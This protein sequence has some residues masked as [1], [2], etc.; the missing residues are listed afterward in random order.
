MFRKLLFFFPLQLFFVQLKRNHILLLFWVLFFAIT[1]K[2]VAAKYGI[3]YLFLAPEYLSEISFWSYFIIGI[4]FGVFVMTSNITSYII[5]S[6]RFPFIAALKRPFLKYCINNS[7][8]PLSFIIFYIV[9][10]VSYHL[11]NEYSSPL[12]I[13]SYILGFLLGYTL[14]VIFSLSYFFTTNKNIFKLLGISSSSKEN[15]PVNSFMFK[16]DNWF[17]LLTLKKKWHIESYLSTPFT[18]KRARNISH[19]DEDMLKSVFK[20]NHLN[21]SLFEIGIFVSLII[22]GL[23]R[24]NIYFVIPAGASV[25]LFFAMT[26]IIMSAVYTWLKGWSTIF[27][28]GLFFVV[29]LLSSQQFFSYTNMAYGI[30][31]NTEKAEYS[32]NNL[33]K[34]RENQE[35]Y[36]NDRKNGISILENWKTKNTVDN[37][38]PKLVFI[39][40]SGGGSRSMLWTYHTLQV[41]DSILNGKFISHIH[42]ITGSSGGMIGAAYLRELYL[43]QQKGLINSFHDKRYKL[44]MGKDLLNPIAFSIATNDFLIRT[45]KFKSG[46]NTYLKDRAFSFERQL[47]I[48]TNSILKK[49]LSDYNSPE[50][51][52]EIPIMIFSPSVINDGRRMLISSQPI[53]YLSNNTPHANTNTN[54][55]TENFEFNRMFK[56]QGASNLEFSSAIRMSATFPYILPSVSLPSDPEIHVM[57]AGMRDNY[58]TLST[59]KFLFTFKDW[60]NENTS[61]VIILQIRDKHKDVKIKKEPLRSIAESFSSPIGSLFDNLF[62][63]QDYNLDNMMQYL[64][65]NIEKPI[66]VIDFELE[67]FDNEISLSWHLTTKEKEKVINSINSKHNQISLKRLKQLMN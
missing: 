20:Q 22:L 32:I 16:E 13:T 4:A 67:N 55:I 9:K 15:G 31:Y 6:L 35:H 51:K 2:T 44:N 42:L 66:D 18:T 65:G 46:N 38:K 3:P 36:Y 61:G 58:G 28:I 19:Y 63:V 12:E 41:A 59:Y 1:N 30:N 14:F 39:N 5:N 47:H 33:N 26:L 25:M 27:F 21:A 45:K 48:N 64:S 54:P 34:L 50:F 40:T 17:K 23:F 49:K 56:N 62:P 8:F 52:S 57:D 37:H 29:N 60:I 43:M 53:S 24:E 10:V 7:L 11:N